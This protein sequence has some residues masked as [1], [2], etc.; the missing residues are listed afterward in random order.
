M[1]LDVVIEIPLVEEEGA[2]LAILHDGQTARPNKIAKLPGAE[3]QIARS[4]FQSN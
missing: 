3:T 1:F 4:L 2:A